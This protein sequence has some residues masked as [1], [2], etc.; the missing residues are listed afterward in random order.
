[1][2][3][4]R[5]TREF[6][7]PLDDVPWLGRVLHEQASLG[8]M[9]LL[10]RDADSTSPA[11]CPA[12]TWD[13]VASALVSEGRQLKPADVAGEEAAAI[14]VD[15]GA[16]STYNYVQKKDVTYKLMVHWLGQ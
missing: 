7:I 2:F 14:G 6:W 12:V 4:S 13:F 15:V 10:S 1:M 5:H 3:K 9:P 11:A 8:G 16:W